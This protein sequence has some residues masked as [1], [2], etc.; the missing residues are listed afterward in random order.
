M[1]LITYFLRLKTLF[2]S[3]YYYVGWLLSHNDAGE[4]PRLCVKP[5]R[6]MR[7]RPCLYR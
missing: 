5:P 1:S 2:K 4:V 3:N 7:F 6:L